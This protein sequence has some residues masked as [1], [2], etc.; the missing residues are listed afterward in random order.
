[1]ILA[2]GGVP[3][4]PNIPGIDKANVV[5]AQDVLSGKV[6]TGQN[7]VIIGAA[8][9]VGCET[10]HYLAAKGKK[11]VIVEL[12]KRVASEWGRWSGVV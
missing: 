10:G 2:L 1:V 4:K 6:Q 7:V 5:T 11:V 8:V 12:L 9:L 3:L